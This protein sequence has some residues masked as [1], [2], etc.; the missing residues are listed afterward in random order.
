MDL[1]VGAMTLRFLWMCFKAW[2]DARREKCVV[3]FSVISFENPHAVVLIA[4]DREAWRLSDMAGRYF[5]EQD[6]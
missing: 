1:T 6:V 5:G 2:R 4:F 3:R